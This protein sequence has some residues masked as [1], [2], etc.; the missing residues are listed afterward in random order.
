MLIFIKIEQGLFAIVF[1]RSRP[2]FLTPKTDHLKMNIVQ[3]SSWNVS[4]RNF[5]L[6]QLRVN[7]LRQVY[8]IGSYHFDAC[9]AS[10]YPPWEN[11]SRIGNFGSFARWSRHQDLPIFI[12]QFTVQKGNQAKVRQTNIF[13]FSN[14]WHLSNKSWKMIVYCTITI[15]TIPEKCEFWPTISN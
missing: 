6:H 7:G 9:P 13:S 2:Y 3:K 14:A 5:D 8:Q 1:S 10:T 11:L 12:L 15:V 4:R